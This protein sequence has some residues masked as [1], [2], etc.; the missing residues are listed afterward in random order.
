MPTGC[1][2]EARNLAAH[3]DRIELGIQ[4]VSHSAAQRGNCPRT[5]LQIVNGGHGIEVSSAFGGTFRH[6]THT[7][8][9]EV[10]HK[11]SP[12]RDGAKA[13]QATE[14][15]IRKS[16]ISFNFLKMTGQISNNLYIPEYA[17][18]RE[19]PSSSQSYPQKQ[20]PLANTGGLLSQ[21]QGIRR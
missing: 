18:Q 7:G 2:R 20:R 4:A 15:R 6:Q 5:G 16:L 9:A 19:K 1:A 10:L 17:E 14:K 21:S 11:P 8:W 12:T 13:K 3:R